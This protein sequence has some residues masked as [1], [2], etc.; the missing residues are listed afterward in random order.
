[1]DVG[2]PIVNFLLEAVTGNRQKY[3]QESLTV[4]FA[5][6]KQCSHGWPFFQDK[7]PTQIGATGM[8]LNIAPS[9]C[10]SHMKRAIKRKIGTL[11][12]ENQTS[13]TDKDE[14]TLFWVIDS[15]Y[16]RSSVTS[17]ASDDQLY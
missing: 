5:T 16:L 17:F 1:M 3:R 4:F 11:R 2:Y 13:L 10:L 6:F 15:H 9:L 8:L 12:R 14:Q 7:E